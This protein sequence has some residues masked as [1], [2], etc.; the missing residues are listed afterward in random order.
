MSRLDLRPLVEITSASLLDRQL[1]ED[2][3]TDASLPLRKRA[4]V[5]ITSAG[6]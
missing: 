1:A 3:Q 6:N 5:W 4:E 2:G